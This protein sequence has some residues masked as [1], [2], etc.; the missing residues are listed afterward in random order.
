MAVTAIEDMTG[1]A[2]WRPF[3]YLIRARRLRRRAFRWCRRAAARRY[4]IL[5]ITGAKHALTRTPAD[6]LTDAVD[7]ASVMTEIARNPHL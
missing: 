6:T 2:F 1:A 3:V 5:V 4:E 7:S